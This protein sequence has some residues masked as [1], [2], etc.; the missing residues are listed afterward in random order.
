MCFVSPFLILGSLLFAGAGRNLWLC[1]TGE[2][3]MAWSRITLLLTTLAMAVLLLFVY[4]CQSDKQ[5][6]S[7]S[8]KTTARAQAAG[9]TQDARS[10][11]GPKVEKIMGSPFYRY[12]EWGYLEVDP[13]DGSTVRSLGPPTAST[14]PALRP[15]SSASRRPSTTSASTTASRR[16]ST[17]RG[18]SRTASSVATWSS[19]PAAT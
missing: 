7:N 13:S 4:G 15:S 11:L 17:P 2:R 3:W 18:R 19:L 6:G 1:P 8:S 12:A 16:R 14:S 9:Q 5:G 10:E